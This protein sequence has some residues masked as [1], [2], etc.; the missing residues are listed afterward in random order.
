[1]IQNANQQTVAYYMLTEEQ[2]CS[3]GHEIARN[4][5]TEYGVSLNEGR[6]RNDELRP[7]AY[8]LDKLGVDRSTL[9]R[10]EK[11]GVVRPYRIGKRIFYRESD[12]L[13]ATT[14]K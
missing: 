11:M 1:M 7:I 3:L 12:F 5:L 13:E 2:L 4:V 8:W 9:W 6:D 14:K 10:W